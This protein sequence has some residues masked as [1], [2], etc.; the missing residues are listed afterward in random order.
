M[1][2]PLGPTKRRIF[3]ATWLVSDLSHQAVSGLVRK[4]SLLEELQDGLAFGQDAGSFACLFV[5]FMVVCC[6]VDDS[7]D[8]NIQPIL[9]DF[10]VHRLQLV[11]IFPF[12]F[13]DECRIV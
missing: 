8:G 12:V 5:D 11:A 13:P 3:C 10:W 1:T 2:Y 7:L 4:V 9:K 6:N